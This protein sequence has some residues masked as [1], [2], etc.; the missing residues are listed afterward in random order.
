MKALIMRILHTSRRELL[1]VAC[2]LSLGG[3]VILVVPILAPGPLLI[4]LSMSVGHAIGGIAFACYLLAV[5]LDAVRSRPSSEA[6][7]DPGQWRSIP[8]PK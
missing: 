8:P 5:V 1:R 4:I 2:V 7:S 6:L 3:L